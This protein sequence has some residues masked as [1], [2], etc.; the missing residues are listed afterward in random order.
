MAKPANDSD[1]AVTLR[2]IALRLANIEAL[3]ADL[4]ERR[5]AGKRAQVRRA[6]TIQQRLRHEALARPEPSER[7]MDMARRFVASQR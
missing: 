2:Q 5:R 1:E 3:L 4:L 6:A 7:H